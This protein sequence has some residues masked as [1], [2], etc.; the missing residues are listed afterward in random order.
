MLDAMADGEMSAPTLALAIIGNRI[1]RIG[2]HPEIPRWLLEMLRIAAIAAAPVALGGLE[3]EGG[4]QTLVA[5]L[6][7]ADGDRWIV[8]GR[9]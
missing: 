6:V 4:G 7:R 9:S 5:S 2:D 1:E 8:E 3:H